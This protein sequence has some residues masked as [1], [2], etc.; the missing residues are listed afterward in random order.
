VVLTPSQGATAIAVGRSTTLATAATGGHRAS[1][2]VRTHG[3]GTCTTTSAKCTG[4]TTTRRTAL[5][6]AV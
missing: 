3:T 6:F 5:A 4:A 2:Q 1:T